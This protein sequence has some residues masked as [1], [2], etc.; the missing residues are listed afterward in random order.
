MVQGIQIA[1]FTLLR[2]SLGLWPDGAPGDSPAANAAADAAA[3][4]PLNASGWESLYRCLQQHGLLAITARALMQIPAEYLPDASVKI[5]WV[6][7]AEKARAQ[8]H[9]MGKVQEEVEALC[10]QNG[11]EALCFKGRRIAACYPVPEYRSS[12]DIDIYTGKDCDR[13]DRMMVEQGA[14][15]VKVMEKEHK[16]IWRGV[17][18]ENHKN[19]LAVRGRSD[20]RLVEDRLR[21]LAVLPQPC[22]RFDALILLK[23]AHSH[24]LTEGFSLRQLCD[25]AVFLRRHAS[26]IDWEEFNSCMQQ[27]RFAHFTAALTRLAVTR[28]GLELPDSLMNYF[29]SN[30]KR[31]DR[32]LNDLLEGGNL[33]LFT[34]DS[35]LRSRFHQVK[36]V[37]RNAWKYRLDR[38][39]PWSELWHVGWSHIVKSKSVAV[40]CLLALGCGTTGLTG[41]AALTASQLQTVNNLSARAD[42]VAATP[43]VLFDRLATVRQE[44]GLLYAA[45]LTTPATHLAE[46][47][48]LADGAREDRRWA[49]RTEVCVQVLESYLRALRSLSNPARWTGMGTEVRGL[50]IRLD[51]AI[52][53]YNDLDWG[54]QLPE[55]AVKLSGKVVGYFAQNYMRNRQAR[56]VREF[57]T[58]GDTLVT[59]CCNA[60]I[61]LLTRAEVKELIDNEQTGLRNNYLAYL[62]QQYSAGAE[63]PLDADR[64]YME[65]NAQLQQTAAL[66]T[67]CVNAIRSLRNAHHRLPQVLDKRRRMEYYYQ[68]LLELNTLAYAVLDLLQ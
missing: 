54:P 30:I 35:V 26:D 34:N 60:L 41:C 51:S 17:C 5:P 9:R 21:Q 66:R 14:E 25:W 18:L 11:I 27:G 57:V 48:A 32:I 37:C 19:F 68:E 12:C 6:L 4:G 65:L 58:E 52:I 42:S 16:I 3:F 44:R 36:M 64:R 62:Q 15:L 50:G 13:F 7:Q 46:L 2:R 24:F 53:R 56:A 10:T 61:E 40:A 67:Q 8:Y 1:L 29:P 22:T 43:S 55:G 47:D 63:V 31:E 20:N 33:R 59:V 45:S 39:S 28:L 38:R 23:H 49:A